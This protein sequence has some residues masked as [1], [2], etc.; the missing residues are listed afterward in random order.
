MSLFISKQDLNSSDYFTRRNAY[1]EYG[2]HLGIND[3][4]D[5]LR[6]H[7]YEKVGY[8]I[9]CFKDSYQIIRIYAL[10]NLPKCNQGKDCI[11]DGIHQNRNM[12]MNG[13]KEKY[14][15]EYEFYKQVKNQIREDYVK[16]PNVIKFIH[17][18]YNYYKR[19][20]QTKKAL[21]SKYWLIR[22]HGYKNL[23][24]TPRALKDESLVINIRAL[25]SLPKS[26]KGYK[27]LK[28]FIINNQIEEANIPKDKYPELY[29]YYKLINL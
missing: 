21:H 15:E 27:L 5:I 22:L 10:F 1:A 13:I 9:K 20:K 18:E 12:F 11:I 16:N 24:F 19:T 2:Y 29:K 7:Y 6:H 17:E 23:G 3:P 14:P 28:K 26:K 8:N 25:N 4:N